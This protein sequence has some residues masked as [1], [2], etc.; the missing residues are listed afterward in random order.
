MK[1]K[2]NTDPFTMSGARVLRFI[3]RKG[4]GGATAVDLADAIAEQREGTWFETNERALTEVFGMKAV[5]GI[6]ALCEEYALRYQMSDTKD[7]RLGRTLRVYLAS[8]KE[9]PQPGAQHVTLH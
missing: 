8:S 6:D 9:A 4:G 5:A 2:P 1:L 3:C 7:K